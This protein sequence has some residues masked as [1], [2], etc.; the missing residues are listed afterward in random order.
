MIFRFEYDHF[1][2]IYKEIHFDVSYDGNVK[3]IIFSM[4]LTK[5]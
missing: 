4:T 1:L 5:T 2:P 3:Q